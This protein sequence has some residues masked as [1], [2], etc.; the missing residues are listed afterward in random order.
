VTSGQIGITITALDTPDVDEANYAGIT[1][2]TG[3]G[4]AA[5]NVVSPDDYARAKTARSY[6][7]EARVK[8]E[9]LKDDTRGPIVPEVGKIFGMATMNHDNDAGQREGSISW[10]TVLND[11]V[12]NTPAH[13]GTVEMLDGHKLM[14][15]ASN[16]RDTSLVNAIAPVYAPNALP[17]NWLT[18][19]IGAVGLEGSATEN[20]GVIEVTGGG[21]DIWGTKDA[22]RFVFQTLTGDAEVTAQ[23]TGL[24]RSDP[25]TKGA[26]MI[27]DALHDSAKHAIM[28]IASDNGQA[29]QYRMEEGGESTH[30][31]G[32]T[33]AKPPQWIKLIRFGNMMSGW[34]SVDG[35][36][37]DK[38]G[39]V[40]VPMA[41]QIYVG[42]AVTAHNNAAL[43]TGTFEGVK[44]TQR[45]VDAVDENIDSALP[46]EF[47]LRQNYPNPFNPT[48]TI[49]FALPLDSQVKLTVFDI[50]GREVVTL[51]DEKM[52]AGLHN[53][54]F[55][56]SKYA[57]GVYFYRLKA[58]DRVFQ[59]KMMLVK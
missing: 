47:S 4:S 41:N 9:W 27:R 21:A 22:F 18:M 11:N 15:T 29:F 40:E 48:T 44:V 54:N 35:K 23:L 34:T 36:G 8:W 28:A 1:N 12:W 3:N 55:A 33:G 53:V 2:L 52:E 26:L 24:T 46:K 16:L 59:K 7:I 25:W 58:G 49:E 32:D 45:N 14:F 38:L 31:A 56:A 42:L 39:E 57:T 43:S 30:I 17:A 19:D 10:A 5:G 13:H 6:T 20:G 37:W 50:L 51:V